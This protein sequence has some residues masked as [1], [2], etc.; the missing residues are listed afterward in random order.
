M[1]RSLRRGPKFHRLLR[2]LESHEH[3]NE[4]ELLAYQENRLGELLVECKYHVPYYRAL[5]SQLEI[6]PER[7]PPRKALLA[8]PPLTKNQV[9]EQPRA[10]LNERYRWRVLRKAHTSGTTGTPLTCW[11]DLD[12]INFEHAMIW[13]HWRWANFSFDDRRVTLRGELVVPTSQT[14]PP[15]WVYDPAEKRLVMSSYH[16]SPGVY[17]DYVKTIIAFRPAAIEGYPSAVYLI[18]RAF[19][20]TGHAPFPLKAVFTSSETLLEIQREQICRVF[21]CPILDLYGNTERTA[22][23]TSCEFGSYHVLTDYAYVEY[24][25]TSTGELEIVGTA[26]FNKAFPL[27][28]YRS[29]DIVEIGSERCPCRRPF[30]TIKS[31]LG[32]VEGYVWTPEGR[33]VGRLDHIFKGAQHIVES[34]IVQEELNR[35]VIRIVPTPD[36]SQDDARLVICNAQKRLGPSMRIEV[37]CVDQIERTGQGKFQAVVSRITPPTSNARADHKFE[38]Q[39]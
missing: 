34:Q 8:I 2:E 38:A 10:F 6:D 15:F 11:R 20:E 14:S 39:E 25:P 17:D 31:I 18:A 36:F 9:R 4:E 13:R 32:R 28:R 37:Q 3:W 26:L 27:L 23:I 21:R 19:E 24:L 22:A 30:P 29:G 33:A 12:S 5:F 7:M 16:I 1:Q 35:V